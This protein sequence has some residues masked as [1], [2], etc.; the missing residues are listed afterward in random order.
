M[1]KLFTK[2]EVLARLDNAVAWVD[3]KGCD[4]CIIHEL[5]KEDRQT[6]EDYPSF[7]YF[8]EPLTEIISAIL[9]PDLN[10]DIPES[11]CSEW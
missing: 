3:G 5:C 2:Q 8:T 4:K 1:E 9:D 7:C 11:E 6:K 10:P